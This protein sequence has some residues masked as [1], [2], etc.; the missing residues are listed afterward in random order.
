MQNQRFARRLA[1][2]G[3]GLTALVMGQA[4]LATPFLTGGFVVNP[5]LSFSVGNPGYS[6]PAGGFSGTWDPTPGA[7]IPI[8][9]WCFDLE[10][11]FDPGNTYDYT[12]SILNNPALSSLF[13]EAG[14]SA[15]ALT[16]NIR[17]AA[18]QLAIW[19]IK[20]DNDHNLATGS[21]QA[22]LPGGGD[23]LAAYNLA[24]TWLAGVGGAPAD[25]V[26]VLLAST[27]DPQHQN[28]ITDFAIP[29][30]RRNL[31]EPSSLPLVGI[32]MVVTLF[33]HRRGRREANPFQRR[34]GRPPR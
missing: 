20:Y 13:H 2:L 29:E 19:E 9:Y 25:Y 17:S 15:G 31:P 8:N 3:V 24:Q 10:H 32:A 6:G 18:L 30:L 16:S 1:W 34:V 12:A 4:A 14:G 22:A 28:F 27:S 7:N 26:I 21:F 5:A 11:T 33:F 23:E